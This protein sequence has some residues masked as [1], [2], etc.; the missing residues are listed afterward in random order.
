MDLE[1]RGQETLYSANLLAASFPPPDLS[2]HFV[3]S[4]CSFIAE[5]SGFRFC[6]TAS[7][8]FQDQVT[9]VRLSQN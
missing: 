1:H 6:C 5:K 8:V 3:H 2:D 9:Q 7:H 4:S